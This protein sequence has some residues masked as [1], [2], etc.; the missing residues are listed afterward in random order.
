VPDATVR[1]VLV[2][3][4]RVTGAEADLDDGRRLVVRAPQVVVAAGA[5]RTPGILQRSGL[6]HEAIGRNLRLHPVS[7]VGVRLA[8]PVAMWSGTTQAARSL[9]FATPRSEGGAGFI[10]ESVPAHAGLIAQADPWE[11][12]DAHADLMRQV[13]HLA[14]LIAI[15]RDIGSGTVTTTKAGR[16]RVDY[17]VGPADAATLR[18]GLV[19]AARLGRAAG[20]LQMVAFGTPAAWFGTE[21]NTAPGPEDEFEEYLGR[22]AAFDFA[23]NRGAVYS[24]HQMGTARMGA[25]P[26]AHPVDERGH[27]RRDRGG[28]T[29]R[30]LYV[31][32][33][34]LF[35]TAIGVNPM[36]TVMA[37]ARRTART[38]LAES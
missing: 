35:P 24:A 5:L 6:G 30:G 12:T 29:I 1:R 37:L 33:A 25:D 17:R 9:E 16:T 23:P 3:G 20:A 34:S 22:L 14:P 15:C 36:I 13:A 27:V 18:R 38:V 8:E 21:R 31:G 7:V 2:K 28:S 4:E 11:S 32:D 26:A 19:A 10:I